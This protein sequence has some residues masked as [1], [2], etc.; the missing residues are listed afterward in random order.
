MAEVSRGLGQR[1]RFTVHLA[2][3]WPTPQ[4]H[5]AGHL[6]SEHSASKLLEDYKLMY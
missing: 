4:L 6:M 1:G 5:A 2:P 3:D